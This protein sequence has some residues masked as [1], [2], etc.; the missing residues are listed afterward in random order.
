MRTKDDIRD[1][2]ESLIFKF[3]ASSA[4]LEKDEMKTSIANFFL[5]KAGDYFKLGKD[6][7]A[8][9]ARDVATQISKIDVPSSP[10][11]RDT[12]WRT[13]TELLEEYATAKISEEKLGE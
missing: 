13:L 3:Q 9:T 5:T 8:K 6:E 10:L 11:N 7:E 1:D 4:P 2:I 12:L